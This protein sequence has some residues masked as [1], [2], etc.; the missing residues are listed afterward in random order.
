MKMRTPLLKWII[1]VAAIWLFTSGLSV[2]AESGEQSPTRT[3]SSLPDVSEEAALKSVEMLSGYL[4]TAALNNPE[5]ESA[6]KRWK[7]ALERIPQVT[8]LPDPRF[9][10][11][12]FFE[13]V[14]TRVGPQRARLALFQTFPWFGTLDLRGE[15]AMSGANA[16]KSEYDTLKLKIFYDVKNNFYEYAYLARAVEITRENVELLR[17]L[18]S[19]ARSRYSVGATPYSDV[20]K[21]QVQLGLL[22][23]RLRS[24]IDMRRPTVAKLAAAMNLPVDTKLPWPPAVPL[25]RISMADQEILQVLQKLNPQ[26]Q[27]YDYLEARDEAAVE[28]A[29]KEYYPEITFGME[30]VVTGSAV[31]PATPDSGQDAVIGSVTINIPF[32]W[33]KR[34]AAVRESRE[35]LAATR[36]GAESLKN[37]LFS[38]VE[39]ALFKFRDAQRKID[40]YRHALIP[41]ADEALGVTLEAFQAG[42]RSSLDLIDAEQTLLELELSFLR[43]LADQAQR[44][45]ELEMLMGKEIPCE[46]HC[47]GLPL[48]KISPGRQN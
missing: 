42:I 43:A 30:D 14:E 4:K 41:K 19:V 45:A 28:L 24:L 31:L 29:R 32:W 12:Y 17:F 18:E 27:R 3:E 48:N 6:F 2:G 40:L 8:A 38:D 16:A 13:S 25:M 44:L 46:V 22:E 36:K 33:E 7:A 1:G 47:V 23:D 35:A 11:A 15:A 39:L 10:F 34:R 21:T 37:N 20:V 26:L 9:T 5:L